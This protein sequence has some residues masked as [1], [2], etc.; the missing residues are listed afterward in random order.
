M[1]ELEQIFNSGPDYGQRLDWKG[2]SIHDA[3][4]IL[5]RYLCYMPE[6]VIVSS[7]YTHFR[8]VMYLADT[9][10]EEVVVMYQCLIEQLPSDH[11][12]LLFYLLDLLH[13][14]SQH[15]HV[16]KMDT[17]N[18][19]AVFTPGILLNPDHDM[20]PAH[21][22]T[23]QKVLQFLIEHQD[24][25][26]LPRANVVV[27]LDNH[28]QN[29]VPSSPSTET[30][31]EHQQRHNSQPNTSI[32]VEPSS[33]SLLSNHQDQKIKRAKT[34]PTRRSRYGLNDPLQVVHMNKTTLEKTS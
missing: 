32:L 28:G 22:K 19:A 3:A 10:E 4:N 23:S 34:M 29:N 33:H 14:F 27:Y 26:T 24:R 18:L 7:L 20:D 25:F 16:T 6:P 11:Q 12:Y 5:R 15:A 13:V 8:D 17:A 2:Y 21:Y 1:G 9:T 30:V 31:P